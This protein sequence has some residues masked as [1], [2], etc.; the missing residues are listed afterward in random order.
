M[1]LARITIFC[2][3][4][5][6][7]V[8]LVLE[9]VQLYWRRRFLRVSGLAFGAAGLLAHSLFLVFHPPS[10]ASESGSL[11]LLAWILAVFYLYG[12]L[13]HRRLAWGVFVLP[14]V[15]GLVASARPEEAPS[16]SASSWT[17]ALQSLHGPAFWAA[18][19]YAFLLLGAVGVSVA[20]IASVM[21]LF[22]AH[23]LRT[24]AAPEQGLKLL[25]LERLEGMNRRAIL[26]AFPLLTAGVLVGA[27]LLLDHRVELTR[28][29]LDLKMLGAVLL[30]L[31]FA[32]V[33][34]LRYSFHLRGRR[35]AVLTIVAFFLL[36]LT[37]ASSHSW[38]P[39]G[40]P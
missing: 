25:S 28:D 14:I 17:G 31:V 15:V 40:G 21:Y 4:A 23:R 1:A 35:Q 20:F 39:G 13:H 8:A 34:Y 30:W 37:L 12:S 7:A 26:L 32:L 9:L 36:V 18:A 11:L 19:H 29:R 38:V 3:G 5:S 27:A 10:L 6:Y 33:L 24:K 16:E 22:Q 2:F